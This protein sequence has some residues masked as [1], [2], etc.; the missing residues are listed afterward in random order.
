MSS[1]RHDHR[2]VAGLSLHVVEAGD[3]AARPVVFLHGWPQSWAEWQQVMLHAAGGFRA[4]AIDLPGVGESTGLAA[5]GSK[6]TLAAIVH[7]LVAQL[8]LK[9][10][11]LVGHDVG[12]M[13]TYAYLRQYQDLAGAVIIDV[14]IPGVDPWDAVIHN[15]YIW[16]F[17]FHAIPELPELLVQGHQREYVDY[18]FDVL[19]ADP[20]R[21][22]PDARAAS[23]SAYASD[24]ALTAGFDFY[25]AFPQDTKDNLHSAETET[26]TPMLYLR[27]AA[28]RADLDQYAGGF[29]AAGITRLTTRL[30]ADA[31][32]FVADEQ[33]ADLWRAIDTFIKT[34]ASEP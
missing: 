30:I 3:P 21:I 34:P 23:A 18:F 32:H 15:H 17:A 10:V 31:G 1:F 11:T 20:T 24:S 22:T 19:S 33:P 14:A 6:R 8:D 2:R 5:D 9:D 27:G 4:I 25:R 26:D 7:E 16:H 12:G 28:S 29:R 13:I